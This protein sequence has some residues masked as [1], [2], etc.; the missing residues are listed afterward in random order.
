MFADTNGTGTYVAADDTLLRIGQPTNSSLTI[1]T[2]STSNNNLEYNSDGTTNE[3]GDT[4]VFTICDD[5][6]A[7]DG[8][9][10][11]VNAMGRPQLVKGSDATLNCT[12]P[13]E[14]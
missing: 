5:R 12:S 13:A 14:V 2:N 1:K 4:A 6:G 11:Q 7:G 3:A 8:R 10:I 9:Q